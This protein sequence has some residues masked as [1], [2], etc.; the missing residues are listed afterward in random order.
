MVWISPAGD[1]Q[2]DTKPKGGVCHL[3]CLLIIRELLLVCDLGRFIWHR[4]RTESLSSPT[5]IIFDL[6]TDEDILTRLSH[7]DQP[8]LNG[9]CVICNSLT[10][11][12]LRIDSLIWSVVSRLQQLDRYTSEIAATDDLI[13][14]VE[15][16]NRGLNHGTERS[17]QI[18]VICRETWRTLNCVKLPS[19][20]SY[21]LSIAPRSLL[22]GVCRGFRTNPQ[23][24]EEL[25]QCTPF[26]RPGV[27]SLRLWAP[28]DP[29]PPEA[30]SIKIQADISSTL[31]H[32]SL[33][34]LECSIQKPGQLILVSARPNPVHIS[35]KW[36]SGDD[37]KRVEGMQGLRVK[38]PQFLQPDQTLSCKLSVETPKT[39]RHFISLLM[40]VQEQVHWFDELC[41]ANSFSRSGQIISSP[42]TAYFICASAILYDMI[43]GGII[44]VAFYLSVL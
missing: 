2:K 44:G 13:F 27:E 10:R 11:E 6:D 8:S 24:V 14:V 26:D 21:D 3:S 23:R 4:Q 36:F 37:G 9:G 34:E 41:E 16:A 22:E 20:E 42:Q 30:C 28:G 43:K 15:G 1:V 33:V 17:A 31:A 40:V 35:H 25:D 29:P 38:I 5:G 12:L 32:D 18:L 19:R 7:P 39:Q